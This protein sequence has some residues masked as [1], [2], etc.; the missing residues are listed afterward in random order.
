M[1]NT[2]GKIRAGVIGLGAMGAPMA[3]HLAAQ[4]MLASVWN[5]TPQKSELLAAELHVPVASSLAELASMCNVILIC[6]SADNDLLEVI[7]MLLPDLKP[8]SVVIDTSTVSPTTAIETGQLL[9]A[10][11]VHFVDAPV[12]GGV[13]GAI[14]GSL[15]VMAGGK[16]A[17][18]LRIQPVLA[19]ISSTVTHMGPVG[20]GQATK[21]VNQVIVGGVAEAVCEALAL[22]EKLNLPSE[23]LLSVLGAGAAGSWFL[24]HR[25]QTM[26]NDQFEKGFKLELLLKDLKIIRDLARE[27]D[28]SMSTVDNAIGEYGKLVEAGDGNNDISGLIKLK[29]TQNRQGKKKL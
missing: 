9:A 21:A 18:M 20:S 24:E 13:E 2:A 27:L 3:R 26:L 7:N 16:S 28:I 29:R 5:R 22:S 4:G 6:V 12:S 25:G 10:K 14:K 15:S 17:D 8:E 11:N 23:R 1:E 19:A